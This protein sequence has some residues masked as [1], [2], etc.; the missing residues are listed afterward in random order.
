MRQRYR[1]SATQWSD[2]SSIEVAVRQGELRPVVLRPK[3]FLFPKKAAAASAA[4]RTV[5]RWTYYSEGQ[6]PS[7]CHQLQHSRAPEINKERIGYLIS[8]YSS[9]DVKLRRSTAQ[10]SLFVAGWAR[11]FFAGVRRYFCAKS[12]KSGRW[13]FITMRPPRLR[14][15]LIEWASYTYVTIRQ[16]ANKVDN[17]LRFYWLESE[18]TRTRRYTQV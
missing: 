12:G 3:L 6:F 11:C 13:E 16:D 4:D 10:L 17:E 18:A 7:S 8:R 5:T 15:D 1:D 14:G 9:Q 2:K